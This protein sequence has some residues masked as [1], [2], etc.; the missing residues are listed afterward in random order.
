M[1]VNY[2]R[3]YS[4]LVTSLL[5]QYFEVIILGM[6]RAEKERDPCAK[7]KRK[8]MLLAAPSF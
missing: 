5:R 8:K 3:E 6:M 2:V 7:R 1:A 4:V